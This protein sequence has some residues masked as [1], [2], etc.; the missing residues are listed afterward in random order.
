MDSSKSS[1][2]TRKRKYDDKFLAMGFTEVNGKPKC[3]MCNTVLSAE[4]MKPNKLKRHQQ[5]NHPE[6]VDKPVEFFQ[7]KLDNVGKQQAIMKTLLSTNESAVK[8]SYIVSLQ[9][10]KQKKAHSIGEDLILPVMKEVVRIMIGDKEVKKL[11]PLSISNNTVKRRIVDMSEDVLEQIV[12]KVNLSPYFSIQLDESTDIAS[13]AQL[14]VYIRYLDNRN[15][16][17]NFLFC[18]PLV[19]NTTGEA[20]FNCLNMFFVENCIDWS[21]CVG[22]CTDGAAACTGY[23][24]GAVK[25]IQDVAPLAVWTHC[26]IHRQALA[27]KQMSQELHE[28]LQDVVNVVNFIKGRPLQQRLFTILCGEMGSLHD[29]LF[30]HTEVRWLS[31]GR[32][33]KRVFELRD[34]IQLFLLEQK[35]AAAKQF[36]NNTWLANL[37][38]LTD[39][40]DHLNTLNCSLQGAEF[41]RINLTAKV[42]AFYNKLTLW[43]RVTEGNVFTMFTGLTEFLN[44]H[45]DEKATISTAVQNHLSKLIS[46]FEK[47]FGE[48]LKPNDSNEWIINPFITSQDAEKL[49]KLPIPIAE[50]VLEVAA[51]ADL[52]LMFPRVSNVQFWASL[53]SS[54]PVLAHH[55]LKIL[56]PFASTWTCESGFSTMTTLKTKSRNRLQVEH[57]IRLALAQ[58]VSPRIDKLV[59]AMQTQPSH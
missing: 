39:I 51:D 56:L 50:S 33:L 6:C 27:A 38:Y 59:N 24:S 20:I 48:S 31:R 2:G 18:K 54:H 57:D 9:I 37:A 5:T 28:T 13:Q 41:T 17:E 45:E 14:L 43:K 35:H 10:A 16:A 58:G 4:S 3:L 23:K 22:V 40:F 53:T 55:A 46:Q 11:E 42:M 21:K 29:S 15:F 36:E 8:A 26:F 19:A 44:D 52:R 32:V 12:E 30:L 34:E 25:R 1:N 7:R 49:A 47:Y